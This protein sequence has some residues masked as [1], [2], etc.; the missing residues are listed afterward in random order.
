[1]RGSA[2]DEPVVSQANSNAFREGYDRALGDHKPQRGRWVLDPSTGHLVPAEEYVAP[3]ENRPLMV[4]TDRFMEGAVATDGAD[5]GSRQKRRAY[6][7]ANGLA[8]RDDFSAEY[9]NR[10]K[11]DF[12]RQQ[13]RERH[14]AIR[15]AIYDIKE[16]NRRSK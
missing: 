3:H 10:V 14:E 5:I 1:M 8:D 9:R 2:N 15:Q 7:Q 16:R 4:M 6:M 13:D 12:E 11:R